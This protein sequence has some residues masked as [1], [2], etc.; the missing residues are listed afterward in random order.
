MG[1]HNLIPVSVGRCID[2]LVQ[3]SGSYLGAP[4]ALRDMAVTVTIG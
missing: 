3:V 1:G 4:A 2:Q